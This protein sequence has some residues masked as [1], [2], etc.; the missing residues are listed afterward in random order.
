[1]QGGGDAGGEEGK[2]MDFIEKI[3]GVNPDGATGSLEFLLF[4]LPVA[5]VAYIMLRNRRRNIGR[6]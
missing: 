1:M 2:I 5:A 6:N 4:A 3:F